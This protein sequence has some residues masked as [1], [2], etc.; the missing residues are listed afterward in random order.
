M[1]VNEI[2]QFLTQTLKQLKIVVIGDLMVDRYIFG[3]VTRISPEA[4]VPVNRVKKITEVLG[5]AANV[6]ANL[7]GLE[8]NVFLL[9]IAGNDEHKNSLVNLL[10]QKKINYDGVLFEDTRSTITKLR[11][12]GNNQQ[13]VRLDFE[14]SFN[15][16]CE[17]EKKI[18]SNLDNLILKGIDGIVISDYGKG[19]CS[20]TILKTVI[21]RANK[22]GVKV[23]ADPKGNDWEKYSGVDFITPNLKE[24]GDFLGVRI[25]ND[26]NSVI[27]YSKK[28]MEK[29]DIGVLVTTR[30]ER[31]ISTYD[32]CGQCYHSPASQKD[33]YDVSGAGDTVVAMF[34]TSILGGLN[35]KR[36]LHLSNLAASI[37][38]SKVGTYPINRNELLELWN[39]MRLKD[40]RAQRV[41]KLNTLKILI[42]KWREKGDN[43]VFTNGCFDI[44]HRGHLQYLEEA[45]SLGDKLVVGINSDESVRQLKGKERPI[46][47]EYDRA[48]IVGAL[49]CVDAVIIFEEL[50]PKEL[51][52][53]L[54]PDILVKGGDYINESV[55]GEEFVREVKILS[56]L[57]GY[58]SS[59]IIKKIKA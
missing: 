47:K 50:T 13:I 2:N 3:E 39:S 56:Y 17:E 27:R 58:S 20:K 31:G 8:C 52:E 28:A 53:K 22:S 1:I 19:V 38:V 29:V 16:T 48:E 59:N 10:E 49:S 55:I 25:N 54:R 15:A 18:I 43:I 44:F 40:D 11:I 33:V 24:L 26:N 6:A 7:A 42:K 12:L 30:S 41:F 34:L 35:I 5:G 45:A 9:G 36:A 4:P 51:I 32:K 23:I 14:E 37:V 57:N 46:I 21:E